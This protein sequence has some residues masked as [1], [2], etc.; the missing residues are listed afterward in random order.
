MSPKKI[1][2]LAVRAE[3]VLHLIGAGGA[4]IEREPFAYHPDFNIREYHRATEPLKG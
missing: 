4:V 1:K 3:D 2:P